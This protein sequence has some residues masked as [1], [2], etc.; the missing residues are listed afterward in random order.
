SRH[1]KILRQLTLL[2]ML[3]SLCCWFL[4]GAYQL[5][6]GQHLIAGAFFLL[7]AG[8][9]HIEPRWFNG[10]LWRRWLD[11]YQLKQK[12]LLVAILG[13]SVCVS[14]LLFAREVWLVKGGISLYA[15]GRQS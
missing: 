1:D 6:L 14:A 8:R 2:F 11:W 9:I 7:A 13:L 15:G 10:R 12:Q 3:P 5:R 4:F